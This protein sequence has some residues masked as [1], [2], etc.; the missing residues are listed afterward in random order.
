MCAWYFTSKGDTNSSSCIV[1]G[2]LA[3]WARHHCSLFPHFTGLSNR[4]CPSSHGRGWVSSISGFTSKEHDG[5]LLGTQT[6]NPKQKPTSLSSA[7]WWLFPTPPIPKAGQEERLTLGFYQ[8]RR[9]QHQGTGSPGSGAG[10]QGFG[11]LRAWHILVPGGLW[12]LP[13]AA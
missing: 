6:G 8:E 5:E 3:L 11:P 9:N 4:H 12:A 13:V 1:T 2:V 10:E 7:Y